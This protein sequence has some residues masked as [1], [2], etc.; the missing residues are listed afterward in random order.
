MLGNISIQ[1]RPRNKLK[2]LKLE[3][4]NPGE[5][6]MN[7]YGDKMAVPKNKL[8]SNIARG[9]N[10]IVEKYR[11]RDNLYAEVF[12]IANKVMNPTPR[13]GSTMACSASN[14]YMLFGLNL[15]SLA[16]VWE[17]KIYDKHIEWESVAYHSQ[18]KVLGRF[19]HTSTIWNEKIYTFGGCSMFN[20]KR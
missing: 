16:E 20:K 14:C 18:E 17:A 4:L 12:G 2:P 5:S 8:T 7:W 19:G 9:I 13:E 15:E 11:T 10:T 6:A 3:S 1:E